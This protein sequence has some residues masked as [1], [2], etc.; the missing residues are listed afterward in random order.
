[1]SY[2]T[3][4]GLDVHATT[5]RVSAVC[6]DELVGEATLKYDLA[7]IETKLRS[8]GVDRC[9]YEAGCTGFEL[10]RFL[11]GRGIDCVVIAPSLVPKAKGDRVKTD[12][13][14]ARHLALCFQA[15]MLTPVAVPDPELEAIRDLLRAR[16]DARIDRTRNRQRVSGFCLRNG[17]RLPG[18]TWSKERRVWLGKKLFEHPAQ[19][20]AFTDYVETLDLA[21]RRVERLDDDV[22]SYAQH[23]AVSEL[24]ARLRCLRGIDT[25]SALTIAAEVGDMHRFRSAQAFMSYTGLTPSEHSSGDSRHQGGI[26]KCGNQQVRRILIEAAWNN[27]RIPRVTGLLAQRQAGQDPKVIQH[28]NRC[29]RRL[30]KR[31]MRMTMRGKPNNKITC[32]VGRELA[33]F[34]WAI[35]TDNI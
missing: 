12:R 6:G 13:R 2:S 30:H 35:G 33:G 14:D 8:L 10:Q 18:K 34:I 22:I 5:V 21:D 23:P 17:E 9:C 26:T 19:H 27:R 16:D 25:L 1:M 4:A 32:S 3:V 11:Q 15:G 7:S 20:R 24:V 28:A 29:Q 31:W